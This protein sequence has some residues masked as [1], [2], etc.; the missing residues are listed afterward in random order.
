MKPRQTIIALLLSVHGI[1]MAQ[2]SAPAKVSKTY[3][4][5]K[6]GTLVEMMTEEEANQITHLTLQGRL[7]AI[8][9]RHL[10]DEFKSLQVLDISTASIATYTGKAGTSPNNFYVYPAN[11]IPAYAFCRQEKDGSYTGKASLRH[12]ILSDKTRNIEDAAFKG[13]EN[14]RICQVRRKEAPNLLPQALA[15]SLTAV[16][17]P[18]GCSDE[19][20]R[21]KNWETFAFIEGEPLEVRVQIGK[22]GSLADELISQGIQ[23]KEVNFLTVEGKL[24]ENDF[25]LI[26]NMMPNL[27]SI[28]LTRCNATDIPEYTFTQKKYLLH[29]RFPHTLKRIGQRAFS[30]CTRLS[31]TLELP[32]EV[33][34]IE[35]GAFMGCNNLRR[36]V[37]T[38]NKI[39]TLGDNLFG[40]EANKLEYP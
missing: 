37:A 24:D 34:A 36:V 16:F 25:M 35:Y 31:G 17:I 18:L 3:H 12:I 19:Y 11:C 22:M 40:N 26:R 21:K 33:T 4:V 1:M 23:P 8:D 38:G 10:R 28:D 2:V 29:I 27:V 14:L 6:P 32:A 5:S 7:N 9:F 15:D 13:C 30:G 39:T 20:R